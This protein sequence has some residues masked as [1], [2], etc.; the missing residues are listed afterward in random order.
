MRFRILIASS[1]VVLCIV[2]LDR[3]S[4]RTRVDALQLPPPSAMPGTSALEWTEE[5]LSGRLM[6]GAHRFVER[7][8]EEMQARVPRFW[9]YDST[10]P[11][12]W[13]AALDENR[14]RLR[15]II[16]AVDAR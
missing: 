9:R 3:T 13:T 1:A 15:E 12:A 5:D 14:Q 6:D 7:Q 2:A 4:I 11:A 16:G 8:I 10:S